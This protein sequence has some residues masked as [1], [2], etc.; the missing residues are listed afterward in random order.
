M[1]AGSVTITGVNPVL[2]FRGGNGKAINIRG[3]TN[4][5][6]SWTFYFICQSST[7]VPLVYW[8]FDASGSALSMGGDVGLLLKDGTGVKTFDSRCWALNIVDEVTSVGEGVATAVNAPSGRTYAAIQSTPC[9]YSAMRDRGGYSN[10]QNPPT[11][12]GVGSPEDPRPS[13]TRWAYMR[14]TYHHST[15]Q[16]LANG[17]VTVGT[18]IFEDYSSW[19]SAPSTPQTS[20]ANGTTRHCIID[21][22][23]LPS[24]TMPT[25]SD[26]GVSVDATTREVSVASNSS[27]TTTSPAATAT[28]SGGTA[29]YTLAWQF[30]DGSEAVV[31]DGASDAAAF[32]TKV[33]NQAPGSTHI[34]RY[35]LRANDPSGK[36]GYGLAVTFRHVVNTMDLT[37]DAISNI[38]PVSGS[39][40]DPDVYFGYDYR[41]ITGISGPITLRVERYD[42]SGDADVA[43]VLVT[44]SPD[45]QNWTN[46]TPFDAKGSGQ[47]YI[48]FNVPEGTYFGWKIRAATNI[49]RK[50]AAMRIV[51]RNMSDA[52]GPTV[53]NTTATSTV[54]VDADDNYNVDVVPD[55]FTLG[56]QT[57]VTND[58]DLYTAGAFFTITGI[59]RSIT[60]RFTRDSLV[61]NGNLPTR[62]TIIG[63]ST[64]GGQSWTESTLGAAAG[65]Y[66]DLTASAGDRFYIKG[67]L[68]TDS[69]RGTASWRNIVTNQTTGQQLAT[70]M[71]NMTVDDNNDY[72]VADVVMDSV[73]LY[74]QNT[75]HSSANAFNAGAT[76]TVTGINRP[77]TLRFNSGDLTTSGSPTKVEMVAGRTTSGYVE[78]FRTVNGAAVEITANNGDQFFV[79]GYVES[80]PGVRTT[81][82]WNWFLTNITANQYMGS[83]NIKQTTNA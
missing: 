4:S 56:N 62:R 43:Q 28:V 26:L 52:A 45:A 58:R 73:A 3:I 51:V 78:V 20:T 23:G 48:D 16:A 22:T 72:N 2:A 54:T 30:V 67:Y 59:N 7:S 82:Q 24:A 34:A 68:V 77:I 21:V 69:G 66:V 74:N 42:Y 25:P 79:K 81:V 41:R 63:K 27:T 19:Y 55:A 13:G 18:T 83:A 31:P 44:T 17:G 71:V 76:F 29:P 50:S 75:A 6:S 46:L 12:A 11:Q 65:A 53:I 32:K 80:S 60:L 40:N 33:V 37:P 38:A 64:N 47:A 57:A 49:G 5:G 35:R 39:S 61:Q 70:T 9:W 1:V 15:V 14:S 36:V 8:V 10:A